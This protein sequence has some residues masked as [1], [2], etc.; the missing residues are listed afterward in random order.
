MKISES[1]LYFSE[2]Q[3]DDIH[4][5]AYRVH[6]SIKPRYHWQRTRE[7]VNGQFLLGSFRLLLLSILLFQLVYFLLKFG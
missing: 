2:S 5:S 7:T 4:V 3:D 1:Q 6:R